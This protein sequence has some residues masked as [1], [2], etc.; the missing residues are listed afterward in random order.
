MYVYGCSEESN[1][2]AEEEDGSY[3]VH[4]CMCMGAVRRATGLQKRRMVV[5]VCACVCVCVQ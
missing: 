4:M 1:W 5:I 3:S 2:S